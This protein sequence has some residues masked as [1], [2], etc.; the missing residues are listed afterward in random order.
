MAVALFLLGIGL[1]FY[2]WAKGVDWW[3]ERTFRKK[4]RSLQ[5]N[6]GKLDDSTL[7]AGENALKRLN[8]LTAT[9]QGH[10]AYQQQVSEQQAIRKQVISFKR[11][12]KYK[13]R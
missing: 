10:V 8:E 5:D 2:A 7:L 1:L 4:L 9:I 3:E 6:F 13:R 12:H 11:K